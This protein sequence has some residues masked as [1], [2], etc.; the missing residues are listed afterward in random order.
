MMYADVRPFGAALH[1][2]LRGR[3]P[4]ST[5]RTRDARLCSWQPDTCSRATTWPS[6]SPRAF[7]ALLC[8]DCRAIPTLGFR[9]A[10]RFCGCCVLLH[11]RSQPI[12]RVATVEKAS[13]LAR[14]TGLWTLAG[15]SADN[16]ARRIELHLGC[17]ARCARS[18]PCE[19]THV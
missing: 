1:E 13:V 8:H 12:G 3:L 14:S 16:A 15:A 18:S 6:P 4:L 17:A 11:R 9:A 5:S 7:R 19:V 2:H 10:R